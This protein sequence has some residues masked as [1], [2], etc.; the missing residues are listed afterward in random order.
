M[1]KLGNV[2]I[3]DGLLVPVSLYALMGSVV[4]LVAPRFLRGAFREIILLSLFLSPTVAL[5]A[6]WKMCKG[7]RTITMVVVAAL[8]AIGSACWGYA[9]WQR[10]AP[11]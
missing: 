2:P 8:G 3:K 10:I 5:L 9:V 1:K 4:P 7:Q 11:R 6:A